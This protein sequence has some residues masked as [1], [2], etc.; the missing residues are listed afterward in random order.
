M[1]AEATINQ[2]GFDA[3]EGAAII[4]R[5]ANGCVGTFVISDAVPSPHAFESGTGENPMIHETNQDFYRFFGTEG[6]LS[7]PDMKKW[8]YEEG[9]Q[10]SWSS[11]IRADVL[12]GDEDSRPPFD[13][14]IDQ[15]A[16]VVRGTEEPN[17]S[18]EDALRALIV[19]DAVKR[20]IRDGIP[21][22]S[23]LDVV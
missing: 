10:K 11:E 8:G 18:G 21:V 20:A 13:L 23:P 2:R 12:V 6:T 17:C 14:Q 9:M 22:D 7:V 1:Y 16:R 15:F 3:E 5:F 4:L 19:C